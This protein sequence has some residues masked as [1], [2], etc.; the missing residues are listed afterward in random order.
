MGDEVKISQE[1]LDALE[2]ARVSLGDINERLSALLRITER[3]S[4][5]DIERITKIACNELPAFVGALK[6]SLYL[7]D[8]RKSEFVLLGQNGRRPLPETVSF[9]RV[10]KNVMSVAVISRQP[11]IIKPG[12]T[13]LNYEGTVIDLPNHKNYEFGNGISIPCTIGES[14]SHT[15]CVLNISD[16]EGD[17]TF[18]DNNDLS[19]LKQI[20]NIL[21]LAI[22]N[23]L[24]YEMVQSQARED[25]LMQIANLRYF[26]M[27]L[28]AEVR[29]AQR[30][31]RSLSILMIDIDDF[32]K[33][34]DAFGHQMGDE[35][36]RHV[37][38]I[39]KRNL[40]TED[41][42]ARYGGDEIVV[43]LPETNE[44]GALVVAERLRRQLENSVVRY[45]GNEVKVRFSIGV[46]EFKQG[47]SST[48]LLEAADRALYEAKSAGKNLV[49]C[50]SGAN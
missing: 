8:Y 9:T 40:R 42:P 34:N 43:V 45:G 29:R 14:R 26:N 28:A 33:I 10:P 46:A 47:M 16:K 20:S 21:A 30:Y 19:F 36:L 4:C 44:R 49:R 27:F 37:A 18:E 32:K 25:S 5:F 6:S 35:V 31:Q 7:Y 2:N 3:L 11:V 17:A 22:R 50:A 15:V 1:Y 23:N 13:A 41:M 12:D 39:L 24:L 38:R 48:E